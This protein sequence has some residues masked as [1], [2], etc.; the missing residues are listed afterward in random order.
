MNNF[1]VGYIAGDTAVVRR[2]FRALSGETLRPTTVTATVTRPDR[3]T[4]LYTYGVDE[5]WTSSETTVGEITTIVYH[6]GYP[7]D[8]SGQYGTF[9]VEIV[10]TG[11]GKSVRRVW[12]DVYE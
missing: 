5:E 8:E 12:F 7:T 6:F 2:W 1:G 3:T 10:G 9:E 4:R 11:P